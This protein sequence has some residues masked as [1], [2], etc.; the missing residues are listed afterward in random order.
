MEINEKPD[1]RI[2]LF[3][4]DIPQNTGAMLRLAACFNVGVDI[5]GPCGFVLSEKR[6]RRVGMDYL[7]KSSTTIH[8]SWSG[9]YDTVKW[10][11]SRLL[12]LTT[13]SQVAYTSFKFRRG[14]VLLLGRESAGVTAEVYQS[15]NLKITIPM[16]NG[17]RSL[18]VVQATSMV[19]GEALRQLNIFPCHS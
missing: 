6:L 19:L 17:M 13:K 8:Q 14:D 18:N 16:R 12:L 3:E 11:E 10:D 7:E 5:I 1:L 15:I 9:Y 4:P 2:A